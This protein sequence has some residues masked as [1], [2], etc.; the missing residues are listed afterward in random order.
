MVASLAVMV[1]DASGEVVLSAVLRR[2]RVTTALHYEILALQFGI[3]KLHDFG[4]FEV[5]LESD[6]LVAVKL[7]GGSNN[8]C[9]FCSIIFAILDLCRVMNCSI[10]HVL[11][12]I[13]GYAHNLAKYA[14][15][16]SDYNVW[17]GVLPFFF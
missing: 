17:V 11:R 4:I 13:N 9:R 5:L 10:A 12:E 15:E 14:C 2:D 16:L 6:S 8:L 7:L 3:K 1:R